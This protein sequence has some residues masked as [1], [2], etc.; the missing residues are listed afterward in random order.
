MVDFEKKENIIKVL[1]AAANDSRWR[2]REAVAI[3]FQ[4]IEEK[5]FGQAK[6]IF[7]KWIAYASLLEKRAIIAAL[8][9][10]SCFE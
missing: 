2:V 9:T 7:N 5:D 1:R 10:P 4:W 6:L 8:A 3:G